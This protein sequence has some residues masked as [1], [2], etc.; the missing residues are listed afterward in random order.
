MRHWLRL[1]GMAGVLAVMGTPSGCAANSS[2]ALDK[3]VMAY[4]H[5]VVDLVSKLLLVNIARA[6]RD[7]P[8]HFTTV[9]SIAATYNVQVNAGIGP[10]ATGELGYLPMPFIGVSSGENPTLSLTPMQGEEFTQRLLTPFEEGKLTMLLRQGYDVDALLRLA[11]AEITV[12]QNGREEVCNNAPAD[13]AGYVA[14][15]RMVA[16]LSSIQDRHALRAEPLQFM[17]QRKVPAN[18]SAEDLKVLQD[19]PAAVHY[20][21]E[22]Q[23]YAVDTRVV[24]RVLITNYNYATLPLAELTALYTEA[25]GLPTSDILIDIRAAHPGGEFPI[26]GVLRLRSFLNVLT[27]LGR[28]IAEEPEFDVKPDPRTPPLHEN[29]VHALEIAVGKGAPKGA[30]VSVELNG[31]T[32]A[33]RPQPGYQWN[34]KAFSMLCQLFQMS[35]APTTPPPPV[36]TIAK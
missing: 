30:T 14:F 4:D 10:A 18:A 27:F 34:K 5:S 35:V 21:A 9:S 8:M 19:D 31:K 36:I 2:I 24:G 13:R 33:V 6:Y 16:H 12:Q 29:P 15:R 20:D 1:L 22:S 11:G 28:G 23:S 7:E 32:F 3:A 25:N 26:H 17:L